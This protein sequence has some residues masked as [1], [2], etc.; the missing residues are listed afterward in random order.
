MSLSLTGLGLTWISLNPHKRKDDLKLTFMLLG[1]VGIVSTS[2]FSQQCQDLYWLRLAIIIDWRVAYYMRVKILR[3]V[4]PKPGVNVRVLIFSEFLEFFGF[5]LWFGNYRFPPNIS[6]TAFYLPTYYL[7][8]LRPFKWGD[9]LLL[10]C[11][12][13]HVFL[14]DQSGF[15]LNGTIPVL[16]AIILWNNKL[17]LC[18]F[19]RS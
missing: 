11:G 18:L 8:P 7:S 2:T 19:Q 3:G 13:L 12:I 1:I 5:T 14:W 6:L 4:P 15:S 9:N 16:E 10:L 17:S